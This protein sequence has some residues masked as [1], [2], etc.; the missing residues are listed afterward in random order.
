MTDE[1]TTLTTATPAKPRDCSE[2]LNSGERLNG[3][4]TAYVG[5]TQR[6]VQVYCDMTT[7]GGGWTVCVRIALCFVFSLT[8]SFLTNLKLSF[9]STKQL[10]ADNQSEQITPILIL[11][12]WNDETIVPLFATPYLQRR[13]RVP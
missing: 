7:A 4:Y 8:N 6:R 1:S 2:I 9:K 13:G 3:V 5:R 11:M 12:S 10:L